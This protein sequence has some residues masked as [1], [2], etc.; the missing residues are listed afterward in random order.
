[1]SA[2]TEDM[3]SRDRLIEL[4]ERETGAYGRTDAG[5]RA[6]VGCLIDWINARGPYSVDQ[7]HGMRAQI[8]SVL[9]TR[10]RLALDRARFPAIAT[11]RIERPIFVVGFPR[12]GTT[13]LH[14]LFAEDPR[15]HAPQAWHSHV[16]SPPPGQTPVC[17]GRF[18]LARRALERL[19]DF[20]PGLL[21]LHPYWDKYAQ[22]LIED[23]ELLTLDFRHAY[24]TLLYKVPTLEVTVD[25]G[26][27]DAAAAYDFHRELLQHLQWQTGKQRW[28]CKGVWHQFHLAT[29]LDAFP[30][31]VCV[32]PHRAP[33]ETHVSMI[34]IASVLYDAI[35]GGRTAWKQQARTMAETVSAGLDQVLASPA[36]DDPRVIHLSFTE[37]AV[38][39]IAAVRKVYARADLPFTVEFETRM[40]GWLS[41]PS[42]RADRYGRFPYSAAA[43]DLSESWLNELFKS[44]RRRF[45]LA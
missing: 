22:A 12:S 14:S 42:N 19:I 4:A 11:E 17:V 30:D 25:L 18:E 41:D 7:L 43:F 27:Y 45:E 21:Q 24:S 6:R 38:D 26:P 28:A 36:V 15:V 37:V 2:R 8:Q 33:A 34:A 13:L 3:L 29:L 32:W 1:M 9:A 39:P 5:L 10:L 31:A 40:R 16:P 23:D 35:D 44:Y 20:V